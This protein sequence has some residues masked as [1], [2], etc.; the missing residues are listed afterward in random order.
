MF[1][2]LTRAGKPVLVNMDNVAWV[3]PSPGGGARIVFNATPYL[4][5]SDNGEK[6]TFIDM[7]VDQPIDE[8]HGPGA[9]RQGGTPPDA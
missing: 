2:E 4:L 8:L 7:D 6:P 5:K 3:V 9:V 1:R